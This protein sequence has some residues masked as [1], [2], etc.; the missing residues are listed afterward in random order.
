M[1]LPAPL[2]VEDL[3]AAPLRVGASL[4]P[5][6][7]R[8]A[9]LA[10]WKNRLNVW[11]ESV[12]T[13][14]DARCVTAETRGVQAHHWTDDPR[15]LL[16]TSDQSGDEN[17][18]L[19][20]VDL[21]APGAEAVDLTPVEGAKLVALDQPVWLPG[22]AII[23]INMREPAEFDLVEVDVATGELTTLIQNFHSGYGSWLYG[24]GGEL[25]IV[26]A[27]ENGDLELL[28][29]DSVDCTLRTLT[30]F[31]GADYVLGVWPLEITPDGKGA[32]AGSN[33]N[34]DL[35]RVVHIDFATGEETEVD[36]HPTYELDP[37][38][39]VWAQLPSPLIRRRRT[40]ELIGVRYLGERQVIRT[41]DP[42]FAEVLARLETLSDGDV[43][44]L[45]SDESEQRWVVSFTHDRD[46][47]TYFYDHATGE[48]RLLFRS[49][50]NLDPRD[51][52]P[53]TPVTVT[54]RDG[55][56]LPCHLTLPVG[57]DPTRLPLLL[58]VH[59]GPWT[60]DS[61]GFHTVAQLFANRGYAVL[62]VNFRGSTGYGKAFTQAAVGEFA[63]KMHDDLVDG[64][65]WAVEQGTRTRAG[66]PSWGVRTAVTRRSS[67]PP[68]L[69]TSSPPPSTSSASPTSSP[70]C[71]VSP[72]RRRPTWPTTGTATW[73][74]R[75]IPARRPRYSPGLPSAASTRSVS[76]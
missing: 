71:A 3:F 43:S 17:F 2:S 31:D 45:S 72:S 6:G 52:A 23:Q 63:G 61:W 41:L 59:G 53:M 35:T 55:L 15:W 37:R 40:G 18:H 14:G 42:H 16:Y 65:R 11:I 27:T 10:P 39:R 50:E 29:K 1:S 12:D 38:G 28:H 32:W 8:I 4:S 76:R 47:G 36:S 22:K 33:R 30:T 60:R 51:L 54:S 13:P 44:A 75:R 68:S 66:W 26:E 64:V 49:R 20:R 34:R 58:F 21:D 7:T 57:I 74:I 5:D 56:P 9:Y 24:P 69:R 48:S 70:S 62:Q 19:H 73:A 67:V 46:P 25:Y